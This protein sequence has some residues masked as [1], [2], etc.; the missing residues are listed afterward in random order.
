M[1]KKI[2]PGIPIAVCKPHSPEIRK[3]KC[4]ADFLPVFN[5]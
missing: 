1:A 2:N 4:R 5:V 3:E